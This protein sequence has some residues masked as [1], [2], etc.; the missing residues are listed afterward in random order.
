M[1]YVQYY[2][3]ILEYLKDMK[4]YFITDKSTSFLPNASINLG[5]PDDFESEIQAK[6]KVSFE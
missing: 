1:I 3:F 5:S 4:I 6:V 2:F